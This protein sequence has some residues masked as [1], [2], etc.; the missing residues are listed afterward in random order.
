MQYG[1][2]ISSC[3]SISVVIFDISIPRFETHMD[4]EVPFKSLRSDFRSIILIYSS[5]LI[6]LTNSIVIL[7]VVLSVIITFSCLS[8]NSYSN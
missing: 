3:S 8:I 7:I 6:V 1:F 5:T 4:E 2:I